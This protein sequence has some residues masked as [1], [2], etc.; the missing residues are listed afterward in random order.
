MLSSDLSI[1]YIWLFYPQMSTHMK[2]SFSLESSF[3]NV[4]STV[5]VLW[6]CYTAIILK[7]PLVDFLFCIS[8]S[9]SKSFFILFFLKWL[10]LSLPPSLPLSL[11]PFLLPSLSSFLFL[12][13]HCTS[14]NVF[15]IVSIFC[16]YGW[17][18]C[19]YYYFLKNR[20]TEAKEVK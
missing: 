10:Y 11:S 18:W 6:I 20:D 2:S 9:R 17:V 7:L 1:S 3:L 19:F 12:S 4:Q 15:S 14:E 13:C 5:P 8:F 16:S